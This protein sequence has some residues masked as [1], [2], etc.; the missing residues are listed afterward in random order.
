MITEIRLEFYFMLLILIFYKPEKYFNVT[1]TSTYSQSY[2]TKVVQIVSHFNYLID[3]NKDQNL[4][5]NHSIC[6]FF[7]FKKWW[8]LIQSHFFSI[9]GRQDQQEQH[10]TSCNTTKKVWPHQ[11]MMLLVLYNMF[12]A[13][14]FFFF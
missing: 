9:H 13:T 11:L 3:I 2:I 14:I 6:N 4:L 12:P 1:I 7:F 5:I 10:N 8:N